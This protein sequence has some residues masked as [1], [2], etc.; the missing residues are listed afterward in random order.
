VYGYVYGYVYCMCMCMCMGMCIVCICVCICVCVSVCV[1]V[2]VSYVYVYVY[3]YVHVYVYVYVN[4][5]VYVNVCT[6]C[7]LFTP[8]SILQDGSGRIDA[9]EILEVLPEVLGTEVSDE[10]RAMLSARVMSKMDL[11]G[12]GF[13][14]YAEF[15]LAWTFATGATRVE[16]KQVSTPSLTRSQISAELKPPR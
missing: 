13:V 15:R 4:A 2:C 14:D 7:L 16:L 6:Y 5:Y 1:C 8:I 10:E 11:D 12:D 3:V 9:N